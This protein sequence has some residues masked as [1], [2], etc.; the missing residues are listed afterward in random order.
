[1]ASR[2]LCAGKLDP[3]DRR[4]RARE[5]IDCEFG[6]ALGWVETDGCQTNLA[7]QPGAGKNA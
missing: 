4:R 1:M 2:A 6:K 5:T 7:A 3:G